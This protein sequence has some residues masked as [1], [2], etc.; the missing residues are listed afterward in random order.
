MLNKIRRALASN[1]E[2]SPFTPT[3]KA[4]PLDV[5]MRFVDNYGDGWGSPSY[6]II[7]GTVPVPKMGNISESYMTNYWI[8]D[9]QDTK[10]DI[11]NCWVEES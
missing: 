3:R 1:P 11:R 6:G 8:I 2:T 4:T 5:G 9:L 7:A 10:H